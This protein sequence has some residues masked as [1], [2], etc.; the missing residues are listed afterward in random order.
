MDT[1]K[2]MAY[3]VVIELSILPCIKA[4]KSTQYEE[5]CSNDLQSNFF[6]CNLLTFVRSQYF[7]RV[8]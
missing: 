8:C 2:N 4:G 5:C 6:F 3:L 7:L 1:S